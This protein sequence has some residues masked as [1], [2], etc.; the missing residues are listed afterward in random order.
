MHNHFI[1]YS[2]EEGVIDIP[3]YASEGVKDT[4]SLKWNRMLNYECKE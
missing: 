3:E 1:I 2:A 4:K